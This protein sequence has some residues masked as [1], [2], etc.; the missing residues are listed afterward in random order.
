MNKYILIFISSCIYFVSNAQLNQSIGKFESIS[1]DGGVYSIKTN[2]AIVKLSAYSPSIIRVRANKVD[3]WDDLSYAVI[4]NVDSKIKFT[5]TEQASKLIFDTDSI[6]LV[7][8]KNP[9]RFQFFD[10]KNRLLN[11]DE[12]SFGVSWLGEEFTNYKKIQPNEKFIGLGEKTGN[13]NRKGESYTNWNTDN[14]GYGTNADPIYQSIPFYIGVHNG[15]QYGIFVD[16]SHKS[17]FN[18]GGSND[19]FASFTTEAG[20]LNYY[21]IAHSSVAKIVESYTFLTGRIQMPPLWS[22]GFQQCKYSYYPESEV[23]SIAITFREKQIPLDVLYLDIHY[24]DAYKVFTWNKDRFP[25]PKRMTTDLKNMG[26]HTAV[27]ID[28]GIKKE[29]GYKAYEEGVKDSLF[30]TYP[31]KSFYTGQVWPGWCHFPDFTNEKTR[32]WWGNS[33]KS[34]Y[35][36]NGVEGFWNDMNEPSTWGQNFPNLVEFS[37]ERK[38]GTHRKGHNIYGLKMS[39]STLEGTQKVMDGKRPFV[40]TRAGYAGIQRYSAVWTGDNV[41]SDEHMLLG[42]RLLNSLGLS[43]V[44]VTGMDIGG[45]TGNPTPQLFA[46]WISI[47]A[48]SPFFRAHVGIDQKDQQPWSFGKKVEEISRNYINLRYKLTP[49]L[50]SHFY[51]ANVTGMPIQ[52]SLAF[53]FTHDE[54]VYDTRFQNQFFCGASILVA[55]VESSKDYLKVYLPGN[56]WYDFYNDK[57]YKGNEEIVTPCPIER[58]PVFIKGG[59]IVPMQSLVQNMNE[60]PSDTLF[61]HVYY[62]ENGSQMPYYEDDGQT[63]KFKDG[64]FYKRTFVFDSKNKKLIFEKAEGKSESKFKFAKIIFHGFTELNK[65]KPMAESINFIKPLPHFDPVGTGAEAELVNVKTTVINFAKDRIELA[66]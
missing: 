66:W 52:R 58:L 15:L 12:P 64:E 45:F 14:F 17:I 3:E 34:A 54:K 23:L 22:L 37:F 43:G 55:P 16:N 20:E 30:L 44:P 21:F 46:R 53:D 29:K 62:S 38:R 26:I 24:M 27:I 65:L 28:P 7:V 11:E 50:Y 18:F 31:D 40:L 59:S 25:N 36:D 32:I 61:V 51:Q 35:V 63:Y 9:L 6:R 10:S 2:N 60:K 47:G 48:F 42:I 33:F 39:Q 13:L 5:F 56:S 19:R 4:Q 1:K 8:N 57:F 49:Y 41:S